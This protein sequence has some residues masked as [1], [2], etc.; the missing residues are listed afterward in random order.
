[1][2]EDFLRFSGQTSFSGE[3][4]TQDTTDP[5]T[6]R[7]PTRKEKKEERR[8]QAPAAA[9]FR[10]PKPQIKGEMVS[11]AAYS[12]F[13]YGIGSRSKL[14][15]G[16]GGRYEADGGAKRRSTEQ[17]ADAVSR[18]DVDKLVLDRVALKPKR[19]G[20]APKMARDVAATGTFGASRRMNIVEYLVSSGQLAK[21][22]T[23]PGPGSYGAREYVGHG[24]LGRTRVEDADLEAVTKQL[25]KEY[26]RDFSKTLKAAKANGLEQ[27]REQLA[28]TAPARSS[29][30]PTLPSHFGQRRGSGP[31]LVELPKMD[32]QGRMPQL[33]RASIDAGDGGSPIVT[34]NNYAM[35]FATIPRD[36]P[37]RFMFKHPAPAPSVIPHG[38]PRPA[39]PNVPSE[40]E[41]LRRQ[42]N[43]VRDM[44]RAMSASMGG[45]PVRSP[46]GPV[47]KADVKKQEA[48]ERAARKEMGQRKVDELKRTALSKTAPAR[49]RRKRRARGASSGASARLRATG[50]RTAARGARRTR[51]RQVYEEP[52]VAS[53]NLREA[54]QWSDAGAQG[55]KVETSVSEEAP[56]PSASPPPTSP[57]AEKQ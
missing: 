29:P 41:L 32:A 53:T 52:S 34:E 50:T 12:P 11:P 16:G 22:G 56:R 8:Y 15:H 5:S 28:A 14:V 51:D 48:A 7:K 39:D 6:W 13:K 46:W 19:D 31:S 30:P 23:A 35:V 36:D 26:R 49:Q 17:P 1:M 47:K 27:T 10:A 54:S 43:I 40:R 44:Q 21:P 45:R 42:R 24:R 2:M 18:E 3:Y 38:A 33:R 4:R 57:D 37:L 55:V 25:E 20:S 9:P